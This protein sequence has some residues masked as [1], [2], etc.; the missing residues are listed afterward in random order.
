MNPQRS[1]LPLFTKRTPPSQVNLV[2]HQSQSCRMPRDNSVV[3][4]EREVGGTGVD[5]NLG[6]PLAAHGEVGGGPLVPSLGARGSVDHDKS[7]R[8]FDTGDAGLLLELPAHRGV[9]ARPL[10]QRH[11]GQLVACCRAQMRAGSLGASVGNLHIK[12][13]AEEEYER[14]CLEGNGSWSE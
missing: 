12:V 2:S 3:S 1:S 8:A 14:R 13:E 6:D 9:G 7:V 10:T 11:G 4:V 5:L